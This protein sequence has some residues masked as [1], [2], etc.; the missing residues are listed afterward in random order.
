[1]LKYLCYRMATKTNNTFEQVYNSA[2]DPA[3]LSRVGIVLVFLMQ[4][5]LMVAGFN[6][7]R[8]LL[9]IHYTGYNKNKAVWDLSFF[10]HLFAHQPL[11]AD[12]DKV[13][14]VFLLG[15]SNMIVPDDLYE[16]NA[17]ENWLRKIFFIEKTEVIRNYPLREA[18]L[19]YLLATPLQIT[20]L[21][22][23]N[24]KKATTFPVVAPSF[25]KI[26][27]QG[28]VL[29]CCLTAGLASATLHHNGQ[30]LW[31]KVFDYTAAGDIA[32]P[33][34]QVLQSHALPVAGITVMCGAISAAEHDTITQLSQFFPG[35]TAADGTAFSHNWDGAIKLAQQL[36][37]CVS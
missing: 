22:R 12:K 1:M 29:Q 14:G 37:T 10:E 8:E 35:I 24:F 15:T 2:E 16:K 32:Y 13:R 30:L 25:R 36:L 19:N 21:I 28:T 6:S 18:K 20:E 5:G 34:M 9:S 26:A 31:H 33:V 4:R 27:P 23:I 17:A 3:L 7:K 11:L